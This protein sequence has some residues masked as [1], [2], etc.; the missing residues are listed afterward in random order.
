MTHTYKTLIYLFSLDVVLELLVKYGKPTLVPGRVACS[1]SYTQ[2]LGEQTRAQVC[3]STW[4][5]LLQGL[6]QVV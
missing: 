6:P 1:R 4:R 3:L 5:A 2:L